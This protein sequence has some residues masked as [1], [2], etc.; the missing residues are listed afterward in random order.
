M[1][2]SAV[3]HTLTMHMDHF[4]P[5]NATCD[6][7][8]FICIAHFLL[9]YIQFLTRLLFTKKKNVRIK[10]FITYEIKLKKNN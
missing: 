6:L 4:Q 3:I 1:I 7:F 2:K 9:N 5:D 10:K 8:A